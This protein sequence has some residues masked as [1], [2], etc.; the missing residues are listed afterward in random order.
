MFVELSLKREITQ[1]L[2]M[3]ITVEHVIMLPLETLIFFRGSTE[4]ILK[5]FPSN[6]SCYIQEY[7]YT[8]DRITKM[9]CNFTRGMPLSYNLLC[10]KFKVF[11][12][13]LLTRKLTQKLNMPIPVECE[14]MLPLETVITPFY[15]E[16]TETILKSF[17]S[18][19]SCFIQE[20]D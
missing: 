9:L 12:E 18:N 10:Q 3:P 7:D 11:D 15:W 2:N 8:F 5:S 13:L 14:I 16:S 6:N 4:T 17:P 1:K 19:N 20:Y